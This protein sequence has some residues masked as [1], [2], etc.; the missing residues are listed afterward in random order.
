MLFLGKILESIAL[1]G[2]MLI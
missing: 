2:Y 1:A